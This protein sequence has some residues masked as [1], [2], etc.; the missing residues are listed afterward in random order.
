[1][2][3]KVEILYVVFAVGFVLAFGS[4]TIAAPL[5]TKGH[6]KGHVTVSYSKNVEQ[7]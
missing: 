5:K 2:C 6:P 4:M 7:L 1:M 3:K